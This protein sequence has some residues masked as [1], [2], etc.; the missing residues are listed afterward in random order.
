M[1]GDKCS[2]FAACL[3]I[4]N[5]GGDVDFD[6]FGGVGQFGDADYLW[7]KDNAGRFG[8]VHPSIMEPGGGGPQEPTKVEPAK[9]EP[10]KV[11]RFL[12]NR[13]KPKL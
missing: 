4:I 6:G 13:R 11:E 3:A 5:A 2:D 8:W 1:G 12:E 9:V 7:M 10:A